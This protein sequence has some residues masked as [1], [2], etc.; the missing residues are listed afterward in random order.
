[1]LEQGHPE[2]T[3]VLVFLW[4]SM[5]LLFAS[6][7]FSIEEL[8]PVE[9]LYRNPLIKKVV[10]DE[11]LMVSYFLVFSHHAFFYLI[12]KRQMIRKSFKSE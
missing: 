10:S 5:L 7:S 9:I 6:D 2:P 3:G 4:Y 11:L 8:K 1:M 12:L